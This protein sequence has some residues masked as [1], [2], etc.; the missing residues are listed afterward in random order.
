MISRLPVRFD[1]ES[2]TEALLQ[3][4]SEAPNLLLPPP[5]LPT[6]RLKRAN[7]CAPLSVC[8]LM[9]VNTDLNRTLPVPDDRL[10][11]LRKQQ[12]KR[13]SIQWCDTWNKC[14]QS[15][16]LWLA[17]PVTNQQFNCYLPLDWQ[18]LWANWSSF[19]ALK[20]KGNH[21]ERTHMPRSGGELKIHVLIEILLWR[22]TKISY[23]WSTNIFFYL[24]QTHLMHAHLY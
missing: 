17:K 15:L 24:R 23:R 2:R 9:C 21:G 19:F 8:S 4:K 22:K 3:L 10:F 5:G 14:A 16:I 18:R 6:A 11:D 1:S 12:Q 7:Y 13:K 20:L